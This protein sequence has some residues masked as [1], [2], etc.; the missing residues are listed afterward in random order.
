MEEAA[1]VVEAEFVADAAAVLAAL[2]W[3]P[4]QSLC[5]TTSEPLSSAG[6]E[7]PCAC[8]HVELL[9]SQRRDSATPVNVQSNHKLENNRLIRWMQF[10]TSHGISILQLASTIFCTN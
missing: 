7:P 6:D 5:P 10:D 2:P 3:R 9:V 8:I 4:C 1:A